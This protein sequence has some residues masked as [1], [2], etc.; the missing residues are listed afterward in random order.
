[1]NDRDDEYANAPNPFRNDPL[2]DCHEPPMPRTLCIASDA[3]DRAFEKYQAR[4]AREA[5]E[6]AA[7]PPAKASTKAPITARPK[8]KK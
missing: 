8:G 2:C 1:M 6:A 3:M 7:N 4:K 5:A